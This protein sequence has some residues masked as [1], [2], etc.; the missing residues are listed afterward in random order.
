[1]AAMYVQV[2]IRFE[3]L[4]T[5]WALAA[6]VPTREV[7]KDLRSLQWLALAWRWSASAITCVVLAWGLNRLVLRPLGGEPKEAVALAQRVA[8]G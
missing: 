8:A 2:P 5:T 3:G 1:M 6:V 7:S 4:A